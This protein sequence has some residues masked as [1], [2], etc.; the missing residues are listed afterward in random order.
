VSGEV[1]PRDHLKEHLI[2]VRLRCVQNALPTLRAPRRRGRMVLPQ[3]SVL[4]AQVV[5]ERSREEGTPA[6][7]GIGE[8]GGR[9]PFAPARYPF[10]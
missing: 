3:H 8:P 5:H 10:P 1:G 9:L 2:S 4:V 6:L 7:G